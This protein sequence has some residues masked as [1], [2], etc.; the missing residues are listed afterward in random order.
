MPVDRRSLPL[1]QGTVKSPGK[2]VTGPPS[3]DGGLEELGAAVFVGDRVGST[4]T[5]GL[6][7]GGGVAAVQ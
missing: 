1:S 6:V 5:V 4:L 2:N 3:G 7:V